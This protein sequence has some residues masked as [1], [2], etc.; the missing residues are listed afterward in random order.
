MWTT[1]VFSDGV[2]IFQNVLFE[3]KGLK[4]HINNNPR[5]NMNTT[6]H[7]QRY[8]CEKACPSSPHKIMFSKLTYRYANR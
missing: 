1:W 2:I 7:K 5:I 4:P 6:Y 8:I 3:L